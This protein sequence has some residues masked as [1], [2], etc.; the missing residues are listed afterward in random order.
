MLKQKTFNYITLI[1]AIITIFM[2]LSA[3]RNNDSIW[4]CVLMLAVTIFFSLISKKCNDEILYN[5]KKEKE[6]LNQIEYDMKNGQAKK[7][8]MDEKIKKNKENKNR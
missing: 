6:L 3:S 2:V 8:Q 7:I 5:N 1:L 4:P